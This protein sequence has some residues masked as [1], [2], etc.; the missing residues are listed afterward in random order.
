MELRFGGS[1]TWTFWMPFWTNV[2]KVG[3][4]FIRVKYSWPR[5]DYS[6]DKGRKWIMEIINQK[7]ETGTVHQGLIRFQDF[8]EGC[9]S[10][11]QI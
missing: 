5:F 1:K 3:E 2:Y 10:K 11:L 6:L 7:R 4:R 9:H 8:G